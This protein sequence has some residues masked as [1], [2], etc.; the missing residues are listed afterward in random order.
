MSWRAWGFG[1]VLLVATGC[2]TKCVERGPFKLCLEGASDRLWVN[3]APLS[4]TG[5]RGC[6]LEPVADSRAV[7][8][9]DD[10][11]FVFVRVNASGRSTVQR[12]P[13]R[14]SGV[15][16]REGWNPEGR[17]YFRQF[18]FNDLSLYDATSDQR[19]DSHAMNEHPGSIFG[20]SPDG[21]AVFQRKQASG[22]TTYAVTRLADG[23]YS[24]LPSDSPQ[25]RYEY[26]LVRWVRN[27][28]G[29]FDAELASATE[30]KWPLRPTP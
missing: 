27:A 25:W 30:P 13:L 5:L 21:R 10:G 15:S 24:V 7:A 1:W 9:Q 6:E 28:Q 18:A 22:T 14:E 26:A 3:G 20:V 2:Q 4:A 29:E 19:V 12:T 17:W 16:F 8:C 23:R 11:G